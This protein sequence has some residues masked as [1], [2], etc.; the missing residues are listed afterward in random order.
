MD[1]ANMFDTPA[2]YRAIRV[3]YGLL[4]GASGFLLWHRRNDV[5]WPIAL[6]LFLYNDAL[7]YLPGAVAYRRSD[8][9]RISKGYYVAYNLM[10]SGISASVAAAAWTRFVGPEWALL[11]I[12]LH[13]GLDRAVFGNML[14]PFSVP[15]EPEPHPLWQAV[16]GQLQRPWQGLAAAE[17]Q[18]HAYAGDAAVSGAALRSN[19]SDLA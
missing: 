15:F 19:E 7:G 3:E 4:A 14:K 1:A 18:S 9:K 10:H 2:T 13:I 5:R 8:D 11:G 6:G 17:A 12:P 16:R